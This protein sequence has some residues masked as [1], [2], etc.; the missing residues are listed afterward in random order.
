VKV[1]YRYRA[2]KE[3]SEIRICNRKLID[4]GFQ[5]GSEYEII[6]KRNVI[7]LILKEEQK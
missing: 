1:Y 7:V 5:V 3:N 6:Y 2:N 4:S